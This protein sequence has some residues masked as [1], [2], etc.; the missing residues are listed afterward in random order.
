MSAV[1]RLTTGC[2]LPMTVVPVSARV[3]AMASVLKGSLVTGS[4]L[5]EP[6]RDGV[7]VVQRGWRSARRGKN[8][9]KGQPRTRR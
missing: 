8:K 6:A 7:C 2:E 4:G 9:G 3:L 5:S 1:P